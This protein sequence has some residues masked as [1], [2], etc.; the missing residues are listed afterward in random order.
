MQLSGRCGTARQE[1]WGFS[2]QAGC[3]H[4]HLSF[5]SVICICQLCLS[6]ASVICNCHLRL[7]FMSVLCTCHLHL[8]LMSV[9]CKCHLYL[10]LV[11]VI[12]I[13]HLQLSFVS[14]IYV[15]HL[16]MSLEGGEGGGRRG[17]MDLKLKSNNPILTGEEKQKNI[18]PGCLYNSRSIRL[19]GPLR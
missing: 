10:S 19:S 18:S 1:T 3:C 7:S 4:L 11:S 9:I 2:C 15:C 5:A 8:S 16:H 12:C 6:F 14:V 13:C 17:G